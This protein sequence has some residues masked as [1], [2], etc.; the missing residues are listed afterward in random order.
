MTV[1]A[2]VVTLVEAADMVKVLIVIMVTEVAV[3]IAE[4]AV[5][6]VVEVLERY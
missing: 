6:V 4:V 2:V 1:E 3:I 5:A